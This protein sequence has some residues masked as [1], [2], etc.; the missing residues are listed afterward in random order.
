MGFILSDR[1]SEV[2]LAELSRKRLAKLCCIHSSSLKSVLL[3]CPGQGFISACSVSGLYHSW[4]GDAGVRLWLIQASTRAVW[5][6]CL[7]YKL[8]QCNK[9]LCLVW[10]KGFSLMENQEAELTCKSCSLQG[11][12]RR[13]H[14]TVG[15]ASSLGS[16]YCSSWDSA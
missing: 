5:M 4:E 3:P 13:K 12:F 14:L 15:S 16:P 2:M 10:R 9:L 7:I 1:S 6:W 11:S 8:K